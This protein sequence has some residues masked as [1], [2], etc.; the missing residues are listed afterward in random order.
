MI[1]RVIEGMSGLNL[2]CLVLWICAGNLLRARKP[3][4]SCKK[5]PTG[6]TPKTDVG[7]EAVGAWLDRFEVD[8]ERGWGTTTYVQDITVS[9]K[10]APTVCPMFCPITSDATTRAL[11][12]T[13]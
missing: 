9:G 6:C 12:A 4:I 13:Q 8:P 3:Y 11:H 10:D 1:A 2:S 5:A 7:R